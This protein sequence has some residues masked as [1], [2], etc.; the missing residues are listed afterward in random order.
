MKLFKHIFHKGKSFLL[1]AMVISILGFTSCNNDD[2]NESPYVKGP[3]ESTILVYAVA[4]NSLEYNLSSDKAEILAAAKNI[5]LSRNNILV[6]EINYDYAPKLLQLKAVS[7]QTYEF[8]V[9]KEY[10]NNET[11][12]STGRIT[13]VIRDMETDFEATTY[14][15]ILWSHGTGADP[16]FNNPTTRGI[17]WTYSEPAAYSFGYDRVEGSSSHYE[18]NIDDLARALPDRKFRFIWFDACYMSGIETL[19][20]LRNKA[21]YIVAYPTEVYEMG[22]PYDLVLPHLTGSNPDLKGGAKE[23]FDYYAL[24]PSSQL[25]NATI[26]VVDLS[27]IEPLADFCSSFYSKDLYPDVSVF[28]KYSRGSIGPFYD[29]SQ[30]SM[31]Q[32]EGDPDNFSQEEWERVLNDF[33]IYRATTDRDFNGNPINTKEYSGISTHIYNEY[34]TSDKEIF[35]RTLDWYNRVFTE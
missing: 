4:S 34:A 22:M 33:V 9:V 29:F 12:L 21:D 19:Y 10:D 16:Y 8:T 23:F 3:K 31:K 24:N 32:G 13:D 35:Y 2:N 7:D 15:L 30:Y 28:Q 11:S 25:R 6:Y 26:A 1:G 17:D 27:K 14:G 18:M 5:D 20:Q